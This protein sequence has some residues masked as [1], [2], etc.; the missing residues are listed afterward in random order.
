MSFAWELPL[1]RHC[2]TSA[3]VIAKPFSIPGYVGVF[4]TWSSCAC[5]LKRQDPTRAHFLFCNYKAF[6]FLRK[7][8]CMKSS[9]S[10]HSSCTSLACCSNV[11][12][13]VFCFT[14]PGNTTGR[15]LYVC[16]LFSKKEISPEIKYVHFWDE[17]TLQRGVEQI[18]VNE[19]QLNMRDW[20]CRF[21]LLKWGKNV[22]VTPKVVLA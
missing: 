1:G 17:L 3:R 2:P 5:V 20:W 21:W 15:Y 18:N 12:R 14:D 8:I 7:P 9:C 22:N 6:C 4:S 16:M 10:G 13:S 11:V 19:I